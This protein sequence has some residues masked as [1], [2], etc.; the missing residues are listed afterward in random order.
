MEQVS[1]RSN[2][3]KQAGDSLG[4]YW[5]WETVDDHQAEFPKVDDEPDDFKVPTFDEGIS[6][7]KQVA[8]SVIRN[9]QYNQ[10]NNQEFDR[11]ED[12]FE[13]IIDSILA[14]E[15]IKAKNKDN[16]PL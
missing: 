6:G 1:K 12:E 16:D 7:L 4:S 15:T 2:A 9:N 14:K 13:N 8:Q 11:R 5:S 3:S 10:C